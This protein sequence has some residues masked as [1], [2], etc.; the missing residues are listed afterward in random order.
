MDNNGGGSNVNLI[1]FLEQ[2]AAITATAEK[3]QKK[4]R[5]NILHWS[6]AQWY[7]TTGCLSF[8]PSLNLWMTTSVKS[9]QAIRKKN[10]LA[11]VF[12]LECLPLRFHTFQLHHFSPLDT[13][14]ALYYR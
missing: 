3:T 9:C 13:K 2:A 6:L 5:M 11:H 12:F 14:W 8:D 4:I 7:R 1:P 10:N